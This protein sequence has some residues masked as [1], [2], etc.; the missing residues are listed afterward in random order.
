MSDKLFEIESEKPFSESMIWQLNRDFYNREGIN[1][2]SSGGVPHHLTS[3]SM[4]GKTYAELI[5]GFLK[6]LALKG[7]IKERVYILELGAGHGRLAFHILKHLERLEENANLKLPPFCYILSDIVEKNLTFFEE[8]TQF[9]PYF[10]KGNL[11]V[12]YFDAVESEELVLRKAN[13]TIQPKDLNQPLLAVANYFFDSIPTDV[14][15]FQNTNASSCSVSIQSKVDPA[16][17]KPILNDLELTMHRTLLV[18]PHYENSDLN[19][20]LESYR[21]SVFNTFLFF[22]KTGLNCIE[23]L[24]NLSNKGLLLLSMDKG[25]HEIHDL[26]NVKE[27]DM[28][29]HGSFSFWVNFH[30]LGAYCEQK[31]G[32]ALFP[33]Y[34]NY[35]LELACLMFLPDAES[36]NETRSAY[37]RFVDDFGPDDFTGMKKFTYKHIAN[38]E[39]R[40]LIGVLRMS[41]YDSAMFINVL[42]RLKQVYGRITFNDRTRLA[43]TM[44]Q[45]WN[46]YFS[47]NES[48]DLAF[49]IGGMLYALGY[50]QKA[51]GY[52]EH[53]VVNY[54]ETKDE[55]YNRALCYYQLRKD[56][57]FLATVKAAKLAFPGYEKFDHLDKLDLG[58]A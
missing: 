17:Q 48:E 47:L 28:V 58:A 31:G 50:Y 13:K 57:Q 4:V 38:M 45:T 10:E 25:F 30:A 34:S 2:W 29:S 14:F 16:L 8:H 37:Q 15:H 5:F 22:P 55:F 56:S 39:L 44:D 23:N 24:R 33:T 19:E 27:P 46:M 12:A 11:E 21:Q 36:Y 54:G 7:Q 6:D 3:N 42:P 9:Q 41:A 51:L 53:S 49:E 40:E 26:E 35:H 52:F 32:T 20:I 43:Q 18:N 1:A